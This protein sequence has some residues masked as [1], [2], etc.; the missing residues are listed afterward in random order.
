MRLRS[1]AVVVGA[2]RAPAAGSVVLFRGDGAQRLTLETG[3]FGLEIK[4]ALCC[5]IPALLERTCIN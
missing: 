5:I 4:R 2:G 1:H 3:K